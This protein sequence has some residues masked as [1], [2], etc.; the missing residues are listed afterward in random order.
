[1]IFTGK[2]IER[3]KERELWYNTDLLD[4]VIWGHLRQDVPYDWA[5]QHIDH[6]M[7]ILRP[8]LK[9]AAKYAFDVD[10]EAENQRKEEAA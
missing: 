5:E 7:E 4:S 8:A 3:T 2:L 1:M 6:I 9:E 10:V